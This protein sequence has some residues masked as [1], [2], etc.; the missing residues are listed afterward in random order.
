MNK[1]LEERVES[2][3]KK[4]YELTDAFSEFMIVF[5]EFNN[6]SKDKIDLM[7][8]IRAEGIEKRDE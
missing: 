2:L 7:K 3:E 6:F 4:L 5:S 1:T 8:K